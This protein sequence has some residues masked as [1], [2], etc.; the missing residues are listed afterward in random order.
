M[1]DAQFTDGAYE[2]L[3]EWELFA[4][5]L[6]RLQRQQQKRFGDCRHATTSPD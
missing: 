3:V 5:D 4:G 1:P 2:G 6:R